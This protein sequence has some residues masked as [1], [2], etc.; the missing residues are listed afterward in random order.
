MSVWL[1]AAL[2]SKVFSYIAMLA[3][4]GGLLMVFLHPRQFLL[5]RYVLPAAALGLVSVCVFFLVQ[6][7]M[8]NQQGLTGMFDPVIGQ[9]FAESTLGEGL[10]WRLAGFMLAIV[11]SICLLLAISVARFAAWRTAGFGLAACASAVLAISFAILGH[12]NQAGL[13]VRLAASVHFVVVSFWLGALWPLWRVCQQ[14]A[15]S[16]S[17]PELAQ[18]TALLHRFGQIAWVFLALMIVSGLWIAFNLVGAWSALLDSLH[19]R[20]LLLKLLLV[21]MLLLIGAANK[22]VWVSRLRAAASERAASDAVL[23][24]ADARQLLA[25]RRSITAEMVLAMAVVVATALLTTLEGPAG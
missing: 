2:A 20:L 10:K 7:G 6:I 8:V 3:V 22:F 21:S 13:D 23:S 14:V 9:I 12:V 5:V 1:L 17:N 18:L 16:G 15:A 4:V 24:V 19:G 25:L 11:A